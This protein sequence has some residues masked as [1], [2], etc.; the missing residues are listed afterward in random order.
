[1]MSVAW[2]ATLGGNLTMIGSSANVLAMNKVN[3][4]GELHSFCLAAHKRY[5]VGRGEIEKQNINSAE[6]HERAT[7]AC[8][9][10]LL[11]KN[12][13]FSGSLNALLGL[14]GVYYS[15]RVMAS[16]RGEKKPEEEIV[17]KNAAEE[18]VKDGTLAMGNAVVVE[19]V[20]VSASSVTVSVEMQDMAQRRA[21]SQSLLGGPGEVDTSDLDVAMRVS[22]F[23]EAGG[24]SSGASGSFSPPDEDRSTAHHHVAEAHSAVAYQA[25]FRITSAAADLLGVPLRD[26]LLCRMKGVDLMTS[27]CS[28]D[29]TPTASCAMDSPIAVHDA[30]TFRLQ[31]A[32]Q[33]ATLRKQI[34]GLVPAS[35]YYALLGRSRKARLL[36]QVL[37]DSSWLEQECGIFFEAELMISADALRKLEEHLFL[38]HEAVLVGVDAANSML[39]VEAYPEFHTKKMF[40]FRLITSV[41]NSR[42]PRSTSCVDDVRGILILSMFIS[43]IVAASFVKDLPL[44]A[45][46]WAIALTGLF[47]RVITWKQALGGINPAVMIVFALSDALDSAMAESKAKDIIVGGPTSPGEGGR[48]ERESILEDTTTVVV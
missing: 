19:A 31:N 13:V 11:E 34:V 30:F 4:G 42:P 33:C 38:E 29:P 14:V 9:I 1:M 8:S 12:F 41:A 25:R 3:P 32:E 35:P 5:L 27:S 28:D 47:L 37:V 45:L 43:L 15:M 23:G 44:P 26:S 36:Y 10:S 48:D 18:Q 24:I 46:F 16:I 21:M 20:A 22:S 6:V 17:D 39:L 2:C 40:P 7:K